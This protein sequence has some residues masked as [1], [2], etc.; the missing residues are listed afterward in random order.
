[1]SLS[2]RM[3]QCRAFDATVAVGLLSGI[4]M[5]DRNQRRRFAAVYALLLCFGLG[6]ICCAPMIGQ[7]GHRAHPPKRMEK[8]QIEQLEG[9]WKQATLSGDVSVMDK[10]LADD[11]LGVTA[12]GDLVT[13]SQQ[14][15]RMRNRQVMVTK[16]DTSELK[17]KLIGQIAIVTSLAQIEAVAEGRTVS[18]QYRYT[19]IYQRLPNGTWKITSFEATR[20]PNGRPGQGQS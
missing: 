14:L 9:Q 20:I 5:S 8:E 12:A 19:R 17:F 16:L 4:P 1:M 7:K 3:D 13:K 2:V 15:D 18:G 11:Y 6:M 10:L